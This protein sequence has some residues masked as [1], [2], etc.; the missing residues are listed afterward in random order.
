MRRY[1]RVGDGTGWQDAPSTLTPRNAANMN[2]PDKGCYDLDI[3]VDALE[4]DLAAEYSASATYALGTYCIRN[5]VFYKCTTAITTPEAWNAAH[6]TQIRIGDV[7]KVLNDSVTT[8]ALPI[9]SYDTT[10]ISFL[11]ASVRKCGNVISMSIICHIVSNVPDGQAIFTSPVAPAGFAVL[12]ISNPAS[13]YNLRINS[14]GSV[15]AW[16]A[17]QTGT[18]FIG[19]ATFIIG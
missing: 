19:G 13:R 5:A 12:N 11:D 4:N 17:I 8:T 16:G 6:W 15:T 14:N 9:S 1:I 18:Y 10:Y 7:L 2:I 3:A